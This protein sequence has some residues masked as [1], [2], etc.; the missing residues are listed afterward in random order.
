MSKLS[1]EYNMVY[2]GYEHLGVTKK[3]EGKLKRRV[4]QSWYITEAGKMC[5]NVGEGVLELIEEK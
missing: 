4:L 1:L 5:K 2:R 3:V